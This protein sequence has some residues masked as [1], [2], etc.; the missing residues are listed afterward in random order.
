[1]ENFGILTPG[2]LN[3]DLSQKMTEMISKWFFASFRTLPFVFLYGD[4]EPRSWGGAFKRPPPPP[5][6][7]WKIQRPSSARVNVIAQCPLWLLLTDLRSRLQ[8]GANEAFLLPRTN[9]KWW[10]MS[11]W[12]VITRNNIYIYMR[13]KRW[14]RM[15]SPYGSASEHCS[16]A[17]G[18]IRVPQIVWRAFVGLT[19]CMYMYKRHNRQAFAARWY[20]CS[21]QRPSEKLFWIRP[22]PSPPQRPSEKLF[23]IRPCHVINSPEYTL[24][25]IVPPL[26]PPHCS[27]AKA[28]PQCMYMKRIHITFSSRRGKSIY[29]TL[30]KFIA[31]SRMLQ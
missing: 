21:P 12:S 27:G 6:R 2:D 31:T 13:I 5:S 29:L 8:Q 4:Q 9:D 20:L 17:H 16:V 1:M 26:S 19:G 24:R 25:D 22:C 28:S 3:F 18:G 23:W 11:E 14:S 7:R 15:M 30:R 10:V